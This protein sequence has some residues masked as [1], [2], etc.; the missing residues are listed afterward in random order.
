MDRT[1]V[2]HYRRRRAI[3]LILRAKVE[4]IRTGYSGLAS[5]RPFE[6]TLDCLPI[7]SIHGFGRLPSLKMI[8]YMINHL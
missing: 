6:I 2:G 8:Y 3:A 4:A 7:V 5:I 1:L